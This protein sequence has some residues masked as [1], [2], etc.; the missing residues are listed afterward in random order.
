[1]KR[2][3]LAPEVV[4]TSALDCGP[5]ALKALLEGLGIP[6]GYD[7]LREACQTDLDGTSIDTIEQVAIDLGLGAEQVMVPRD[8]LARDPAMLPAIVVVRLPQNLTHFVLVWRKLGPFFQ[9]MDPA[10]GRRWVRVRDF[11]DDVYVHQVAVPGQGWKEWAASPAAAGILA[12]RLGRSGIVR[13]EETV[14][15]AVQSAGWQPL[16]TLDAAAR[17]TEALVARGAIRRGEEAGRLLRGLL[18]A[19]SLIPGRYWSARPPADGPVDEA[20]VTGA[21]L[22]R[23]TAGPAGGRA[24][25]GGTSREV[26]AAV[27]ERRPAPW[28][29]LFGHLRSDRG[30]PLA[31]AVASC[32]AVAAGLAAEPLLLR[33]A[34]DFRSHLTS[35]DQR[36]RATLYVALFGATVLLL[37]QRL[38][39]EALRFGRLLETRFRV[40]WLGRL[41]LLNERYFRSRLVSDMAERNHATHHLH[42]YPHLAGRLAQAVVTLAL[43]SAGIAVVAPA[44]A[45]L[46][47]VAAFVT[48]GLALAFGPVLQR[49]DMRVRTHS[50]ALSRFHLDALRG[51]TAIRAHSGEGAVRREHESLLTE[52]HRASRA[53]ARSLLAFETLQ[54]GAGFALALGMLKLALSSG[55]DPAAA[56]LIAYWAFTYPRLGGEIAAIMKQR[57]E[58]RSVALRLIEPLGQATEG[59]AE[60]APAA[61]PAEGM[62]IRMRGVTVRAGGHTVLQGIDLDLAPGEHVA[63]VGASGAGKSALVGLLLGWHPLAD[64]SIDVDGKPLNDRSWAG[65]RAQTAWVDPA[66][67]LWNDSLEGNVVYGSVSPGADALA[68]ALR[69]ASLYELVE[70]LGGLQAPLGEGGAL[71]SGG[72]GQRVRLARGLMRPG[73]RLAILDEAFRG[74]DHESRRRLLEHAR[75]LWKDATLLAVTHDVHD[76]LA[77]DRVLVM[78]GGALVES[79]RPQALAARPGSRFAALLAGEQDARR[80]WSESQAWR[81]LRLDR[82]RVAWQAPRLDTDERNIAAHVAPR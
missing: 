13:A 39:S 23:I 29:Q 78:A 30:W 61:V 45:P 35:S 4:Q 82:G 1:M 27:A 70:R 11:L 16:A 52:W 24:H 67:H 38:L 58:Q 8:H 81:H 80:M 71:L 51:L 44:S 43:V 2:R 15:E 49:H 54:A 36:L 41:A 18:D 47:A 7:R 53:H 34:V 62:A 5:A 56:L 63:V 12:A 17:L 57:A 32:A 60:A 46:V 65:L 74:L 22:V 64:G 33:A 76:T 75:A 59:A 26:A 40:A 25:Y 73:A 19:A 37:E 20:R 3:L 69:G 6:A 66:V 55:T 79:G 42:D 68:A 14:A 28:R 10:T 21:V 31:L 9:V 72:E 77:F 48:L 50:G